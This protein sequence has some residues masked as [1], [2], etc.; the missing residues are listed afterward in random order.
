MDK[1]LSRNQLSIQDLSGFCVGL[2]PGS[3]TGLR[4]GI[5][6]LRGL[7]LALKRPIV[8]VPSIDAIAYNFSSHDK[9]ICVMVDARQNKLYARLYKC[10]DS[11]KP[12][13]RFLLLGIY[14]LLTKIKKP[15]L[16]IGDGLLLYQDAIRQKKGSLATFASQPYWYPRAAIIGRLGYAMLKAGKKD[17]VFTL[18]PIYIYPKEC[19]VKEAQNSKRKAQN[20]K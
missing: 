9:Q 19:Q 14:E 18:S 12:I 17:S 11:I 15:T 4:I 8:G 7:A 2:G 13:S 10:Q 16:F 5:T 20:E 1:L 6:T 3:F